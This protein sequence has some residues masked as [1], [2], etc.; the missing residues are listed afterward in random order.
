MNLIFAADAL[1][2]PVTGVGRYAWQLATRL[3]RHP[4]IESVR[5]YLDGQWS[6]EPQALLDAL[7]P[8]FPF[9]N[10][11]H[12]QPK[13][14]REW[15][16]RRACRGNVF[17]SPNFFLP[18]GVEGGVITIHD[19]SVF[20]Y[21]ETHPPERH[22]DYERQFKRSLEHAA[23]LIAVSEFTRR[24]V[25]ELLSWPADRVIAIGH[26]VDARF[27]PRP[28]SAL[29][30]PLARYG[31]AP[32]HY[33]LC[34]STL[35]PRKNIARLVEAYGALPAGARGRFPLILAGSE[36]WLSDDLRAN[37]RE[38]EHRGWLRYL[39]FV[40]DPDLPA[41]YA[42]ARLFV[43]PSLYEGFGFPVL[44]AMACGTPVVTSDRSSLPE[45]AAGAAMLVDPEDVAGLRDAIMRGLED[46]DWRI[47]ARSLGLE[48]ARMRSWERCV[49]E[50]V[51]V[52]RRI[53]R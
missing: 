44:E 17:H 8:R 1:L 30:G 18:P 51:A 12:W 46:E 11:L 36:G 19:L 26:G 25:I 29:A 10:A 48:A 7:V 14:M 28:P 38:A 37:I 33:A 42:G 15:K 50:T 21:P 9:A 22:A 45:V 40:P 20:R 31:L 3:V 39:N 32:G 6:R 43:Y 47:R 49:S 27:A 35:E 5:F 52:Y 34:I 13:W 23:E 4:E 41:L 2:P 24:E 16:L 53:A